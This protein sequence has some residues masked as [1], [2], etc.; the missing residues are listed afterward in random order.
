[1]RRTVVLRVALVPLLAV[2]LGVA[3]QGARIEAA[4]TTSSPPGVEQQPAAEKVSYCHRTASVVN[5]YNL[6][7][8]AVDSIVKQ[9]HGSHTGPVFP[10]EG[11]DGKW[12]DIIPPFDYDNGNKHFPGLNWPAGASVIAAGCAVHETIEPPPEETTTTT[13]AATTTTQPA[14]TTVTDDPIFADVSAFC[15]PD[16]L[17]LISITMG[18]RPDLDGDVGILDFSDRTSYG[19]LLFVSGR[20]VTFPYPESLTTP[21]GL[22]YRIQGETAT[23]TVTLPPDCPPGTATTLPPT[24]TSTTTTA[25]TTTTKPPTT[26]TKPPT[27]T[28][29]PPT[30]TTKPPTG[31]STTTPTAAV[32]T[33]SAPSTSTT[34]TTPGQ[35]TTTGLAA[36]SGSTTTV[37]GVTTTTAVASASGSTTTTSVPPP[38]G[39]PPPTAAPTPLDPPPVAALAPG[40]V[41]SDPP[42]QVRSFVVVP[43]NQMVV[44]GVLSPD[45]VR[46]L[47]RELADAEVGPHRERHW[48]AR[49]GRFTRSPER[50]CS[51]RAGE[52][53]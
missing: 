2:S 18:N 27:S 41:L 9:G 25:P 42:P 46:A 40:E 53:A 52:E 11:P 4:T 38:T 21:L 15:G 12:G 1:M 8:T 14:T 30:G 22:T 24:T 36:G 31:T 7:S 32:T 23:A 10:E 49:C 34:T 44:L 47:F 35:T 26:T 19:Q 48:C 6:K 3:F 16:H 20:T 29:K 5:P 37:A 43:G 45:Q 17:P 28:T 13:V 51:P 39:T 50:R 33:T